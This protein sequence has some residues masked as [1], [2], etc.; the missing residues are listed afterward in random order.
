MECVYDI[1]QR[2]GKPFQPYPNSKPAIIARN[3]SQGQQDLDSNNDNDNGNKPHNVP[4]DVDNEE[5]Q[6]D[7]KND[8]KSSNNNSNNSTTNNDA[9]YPW[10]KTGWNLSDVGPGID[11]SSV[12]QNPTDD[13]AFTLPRKHDMCSIMSNLRVHLFKLEKLLNSTYSSYIPRSV[14][15]EYA[16]E[17]RTIRSKIQRLLGCKCD[18]CGNDTAQVFLLATLS[19]SLSESYGSI[20]MNMDMALGEVFEEASKI[21]NL[22]SFAS[23]LKLELGHFSE[24]CRQIRRKGTRHPDFK[25]VG[26]AYYESLNCQGEELSQRLNAWLTTA[27]DYL[28]HLQN[29]FPV[30]CE[31]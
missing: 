9:N 1:S 29:P 22:S 24:I 3:V 11:F 28:R 5:G 14:A 27:A 17:F 10:P 30:R 23:L 8:N 4:R 21:D 25:A 13:F 19:L 7:P 31:D 6:H 18:V 15:D 12:S 20:M 2:K 16:I 26:E